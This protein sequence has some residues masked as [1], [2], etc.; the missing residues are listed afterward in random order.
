MEFTWSV[1]DTCM[2][3]VTKNEPKKVSRGHNFSKYMYM[4]TSNTEPSEGE[5]NINYEQNYL[6]PFSLENYYTAQCYGMY[7]MHNMLRKLLYII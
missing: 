5:I 2:Y 4:E 3:H 1:L 7:D 6:Y